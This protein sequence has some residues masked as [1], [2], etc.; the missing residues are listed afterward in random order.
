MAWRSHRG[1]FA[2]LAALA[3]G[4]VALAAAVSDRSGPRPA[5]LDVEEPSS[6]VRAAHVAR[7]Q[8]R[9]ARFADGPRVPGGV[10]PGPQR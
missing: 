4:L 5:R 3:V 10:A 9:V 1:R 7:P 6:A 8:L 2:F